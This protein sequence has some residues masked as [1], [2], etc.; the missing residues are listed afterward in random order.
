MTITEREVLQFIAQGFS[1]NEI[2]QNL[3]ISEESVDKYSTSLMS[4]LHV[5]DRLSLL[6]EAIKHNLIFVD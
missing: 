4:K 2:A 3:K 5:Q 1:S 6:R